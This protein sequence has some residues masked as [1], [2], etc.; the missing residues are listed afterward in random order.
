MLRWI[1]T[2]DAALARA[3]TVD[4]RAYGRTRNFL[5]GA[6]TRLSP[7]ITH[8]FVDLPE[9]VADARVRLGARPD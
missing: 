9:L 8:G 7:W 6:V 5:D 2:R 4:P 1:P 3:R